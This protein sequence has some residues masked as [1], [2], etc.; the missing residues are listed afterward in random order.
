MLS[1]REGNS[2]RVG[3]GLFLR[4]VGTLSLCFFIDSPCKRWCQQ[5]LCSVFFFNKNDQFVFSVCKK[6]EFDAL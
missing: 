5:N 1:L 6:C 3:K 4:R 2:F